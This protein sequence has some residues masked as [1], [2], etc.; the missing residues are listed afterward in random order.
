MRQM[1]NIMMQHRATIALGI[2][3]FSV[4]LCLSLVLQ[5]WIIP[6][7][8]NSPGASEGLVVLDSIGFDEIAKS[9]ASEISAQGW[10]AWEL[11]P[12]GQSPAGIASIFYVLLGKTPVSVLPYNSVIH[13]LSAC[14]TME[15]LKKYF[16]VLPSLIGAIVFAFN[17]AGLEWAAQIHRDGIFILGNLMLIWSLTTL[18]EY[19][20]A[21]N[22]QV[23][24]RSVLVF[25]LA[26]IGL[27]CI[28]IARPYWLQVSLVSCSILMVRYICELKKARKAKRF[29]NYLLA[30]CVFFGILLVQIWFV[31][32]DTRFEPISLPSSAVGSREIGNSGNNENNGNN[33]NK[34]SGDITWESSALIPDRIE[35]TLYRISIARAG[36]ISQ[37]GNSLIDTDYKLNSVGAFVRIMP[38]AFQV[39]MFSPFPDL[40]VGNA[41]TPAMTIGRRIVGIMTVF[42][43]LC[44]TGTLMTILRLRSNS[45]IWVTATVCVV[46]IVIYYLSYPNIGTLIRYRYAFYMLLVAFGSAGWARLVLYRF[47]K[48]GKLR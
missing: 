48:V 19:V 9:K 27:S 4:T 11:R 8:F 31:E 10:S 33:G 24:P 36:A 41:S 35:E 7:I 47:G 13:A 28:W 1:K 42:Y 46:G 22:T 45:S 6:A 32:V 26:S 44:L 37:G 16:A 34:S 2:L 21:G 29:V 18:F 30:L 14:V 12:S 15:I 43:Y 40:W 17:P 5:L 39:G 3:V 38:R 20:Q 25:A 23:L